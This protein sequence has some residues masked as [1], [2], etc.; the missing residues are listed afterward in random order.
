MATTT[1]T[2]TA[3]IN[4]TNILTLIEGFGNLALVGLQ[5]GGVVPVGSSQIAALLEQALN[6]LVTQQ[7]SGAPVTTDVVNA[8]ALLIAGFKAYQIDSGTSSAL[9]A[10]IA[11]YLAATEAGLAGYV[12][13]GAGFNAANYGPLEPVA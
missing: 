13:A 5:A 7:Q 11:V 4:W 8:Y 2:P 10:K 9:Q 12:Q 1:P 3:G 6:N